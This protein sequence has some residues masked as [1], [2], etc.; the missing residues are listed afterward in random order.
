MFD[1]KRDL[2]RYIDGLEEPI[3]I[4]E[5]MSPR[6][7]RRYRVPAAIL[8]GAA[9]VVIPA[10]VL[11]GLRL[12][13]PGESDVAETTF[14]PTTATTTT[15]VETTS[16]PVSTA[17]VPN[18][19]GLTVADAR[20]ILDELGLVLEVTEQ[21]PSRSGFGLIT[22]QGPLAGETADVGSAVAVGI[23]VEAPCLAGPAEPEIPAGSM[24]VKV[25]FECAGDGLYPDVSTPVSRTA[26]D[27]P[28]VI[29][30][31]LRALLAGLTDD[32][33]ATGLGSFFSADTAD[34][35]NSVT[36]GSGRLVVDFNDAILINN[37]GTSTGS[38]YFLAELNANLFQFPEVGSIEYRLNGSCDAFYGWLQGSCQVGTRA[39]WEQ[40]LAAWDAE[41]VQLTRPREETGADEV[42]GR[43]YAGSLRDGQNRLDELIDGTRVFSSFDRLTSWPIDDATGGETRYWAVHVAGRGTEMIWLVDTVG[44]TEGGLVIFEVRAALEIPWDEIYPILTADAF[45]M[46]GRDEC[47]IDDAFD[48]Q[49]VAVGQLTLGPND[50]LTGLT[51]VLRAWRVDPGV[52]T[53][54]ELPVVGISCTSNTF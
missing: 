11:L 44:N 1:L 40:S 17:V 3:S 22:A 26:P 10:L 37:A 12:L 43:S 39:Q 24:M 52:A 7:K 41:R 31:T 38:T 47:T 28:N 54:T 34:A 6:R 2:R 42:V 23:R 48:P 27:G 18:L 30:A 49:L 32:E 35:L 20:E 9:V 29:E 46:S 53:I 21:Y 13:P 8:A 25:L 5:A 15:G 4:Q 14:P 19:D 33:R 45:V 50:E 51:D 36:L 16:P